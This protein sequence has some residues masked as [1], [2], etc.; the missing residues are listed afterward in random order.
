MSLSVT[1]QTW[2]SVTDKS[3]KVVFEK[4]LP[5]GSAESFEGVPPLNV[6]IGNAKAAKL[7]YA[8]QPVDFTA[9]T[10]GNVARVRLE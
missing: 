7:T 4:M 6:V 2:V 10:R 1:E 9:Q 3:G 8:G 5:T